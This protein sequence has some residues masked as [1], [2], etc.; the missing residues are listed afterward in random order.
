MH[1][2]RVNKKAELLSKIKN[3]EIKRVDTRI[4]NKGMEEK[5]E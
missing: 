5:L 4:E 1:I 2:K 3:K